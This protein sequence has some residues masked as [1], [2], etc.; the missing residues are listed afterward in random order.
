MNL[1]MRD[2]VS[3]RSFYLQAAQ[4]VLIQWSCFSVF[5]LPFA[6]K[7]YPFLLFFLTDCILIAKSDK[8]I[9]AA[10]KEISENFEITD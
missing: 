10:I 4:T 3:K 5:A 6:Y 1:P 8:L 9:K 2:I 7:K